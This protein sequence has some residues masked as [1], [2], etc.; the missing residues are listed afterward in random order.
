GGPPGTAIASFGPLPAHRGA[1]DAIRRVNDLF[2]LRDCPQK[3]EMYFP[4]QADL[5]P[6]VRIPGCLR[7]EIG[8]CLGPCTGECPRT[9]YRAA[10]LA[11]R[12]FLTGEDRSPLDAPQQRL[13]P[14]ARAQPFQRAALPPRPW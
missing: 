14:A 3:Q 5:F 9:K 11:A 4:D 8:S 12:R 1:F 2:R 13:D 7:M 10:V 6:Q